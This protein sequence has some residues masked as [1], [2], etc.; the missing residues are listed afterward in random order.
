MIP[1]QKWEIISFLIL[2]YAQTGRG[3]CSSPSL[4]KREPFH[5]VVVGITSTAV[6]INSYWPWPKT[7]VLK[8]QTF[9]T[10]TLVVFQ[11]KLWINREIFQS[12]TL[13]LGFAF[14]AIGRVPISWVGSSTPW[15]HV[16]KHLPM[17]FYCWRQKKGTAMGYLFFKMVFK[18][19]A[20]I[21]AYH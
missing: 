9:Q 8:A 14:F 18:W 6:E 21:A 20:L 15:L 1:F 4:Q 13:K 17:F 10:Q 12:K 19:V 5:K 11:N 16:S 3:I 7:T 2:E